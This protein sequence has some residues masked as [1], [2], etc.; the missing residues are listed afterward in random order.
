MTLRHDRLRYA[1]IF[2][3]GFRRRLPSDDYDMMTMMIQLHQ[4]SKL[5]NPTAGSQF[6]FPT[7]FLK[8]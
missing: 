7:L 8:N 6:L 1:A 2:F 4:N 3:S 5:L